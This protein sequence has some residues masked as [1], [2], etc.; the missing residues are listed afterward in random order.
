MLLIRD[1]FRCKPGQARHL[2]D[3]LKAT[4]PSMERED[5]FRHCR[6]LIDYVTSY[7]TVVLEA[8]AETLAQFEHHAGT[9]SSRPDVRK[10]MDGYLALVEGG[11][12]EIYTISSTGE[13]AMAE[14][15]KQIARRFVEGFAGGDTAVLEELVAEDLI[16]HNPAPGH[17]SDRQGLLD[18][19]T[20]YHTGFPDLRATVEQEVAEGDLVVLCGTI[21]GTNTGSMLG[22]PATGKK[23]AFP[24]M[25][26]YRIVNG[27]IV[28]SWHLE[29][30][31]G[32]LHQLGLMPG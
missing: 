30:I 10:A 22:L 6:V 5:G 32:M 9:F 27:R 17:R 12:R 26:M 2:A 24:Y 4:I 7:W 23:A 14:R 16:D 20:L 3:R 11:H 18:A 19:V 31:A 21:S 1:V 25:D 15:N 29:D 28:E 8:E 13:E